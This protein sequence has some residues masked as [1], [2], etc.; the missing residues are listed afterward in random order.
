MTAYRVTIANRAELKEVTVICDGC[1]TCV[2]IQIETANIPESCP[3]CSKTYPEE[4]KSALAALAR[5][6]RDAIK[7]EN[8]IGKGMFQ[9]AIKETTT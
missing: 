1:G 3:S 7:A 9:F 5:F 4:A 6:H 2:V 8:R